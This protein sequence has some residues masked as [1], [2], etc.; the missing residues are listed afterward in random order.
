FY[1]Y[2][3]LAVAC[4]RFL[5]GAMSGEWYALADA[6]PEQFY[7]WARAVTATLGTATVALVYF[8]GLRWGTR[9]ALVAASLMAVMPLHVR[10][11]HYVLTD[12][13]VTF[14]VTLT[15][16]LSLRANEQGR[17]VAFLLAG[18]AA[19]L[20]AATKYTGAVALLLPLVAAWMTHG[21][22]PSRLAGA[23]AAIAGAAVAFLV[24]APYTLLD[25]PGFLNGYAV[26]MKSYAGK[27]PPDAPAITYLKHLRNAFWWP[28]MIAI[29]GGVIFGI[30][31]AIN[32]PG[33]VRWTLA[34]LFPL[35]FFWFISRQ[36]MVFG[37]YALPLVPF[38]CILAAVAVVAGVNLLRRF[39]IPRMVR[40]ALIIA[41]TVGVILPPGIQAIGFNRTHGA[42]TVAQTYNW[43][44]ANVPGD[45]TIV[46]E[47]R[48][49]V[50][51]TRSFKGTNVRQLRDMTYEDYV[52]QG[53]DY[54]VASS[55]C[56][57][58]YF[59]NPKQFPREYG[60]YRA[61]FSR[62]REVAR[63][64]P[65]RGKPWAEMIIFKVEP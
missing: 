34:V 54:V 13:P 7:L 62:M 41:L 4:V 14:F 19:G 21:V 63:F 46:I 61:L 5:A 59:E 3:Q 28:G 17:A 8:I 56:Y 44:L 51:P 65:P 47:C 6:R 16:L 48:N 18:A 15:F 49:L 40:T 64:T 37:R 60:E 24:A 33:R 9:Y 31:R 38:L 10:E 50:A 39:S 55:Q 32:G 43:I 45:A 58:P 27:H 12:V 1:I 20:A 2:V 23:L 11:S 57:G 36:A 25:L 42:A 26:L 53:V 29:L 22:R 30:V 35:V 52:A